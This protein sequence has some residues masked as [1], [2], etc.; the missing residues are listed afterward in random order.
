[1]FP[2]SEHRFCV[3]HLYSNFQQHFKGENLKNQLWA[4]ARS[5]TV[6]RWNE[7]MDKMKVLDQKAFEWLEKMPPNTWVRAFFSTYCKCDILLNNS[8]EVFNKY[9][10]DARE[11]PVLSMLEQIKTQLMTR[12]YKKEQEVG[13]LWEGPICPKIKRKLLKNT[14][15]ANTC[16]AQPAGMGI[17]QVKVLDRQYTVDIVNKQCDCRRWDLT[18]IPCSHAISCL[19]HERIHPE[20]VVNECYSSKRFLL[21]YGP[22]IWPTNDKSMWQRVGGPDI[23]PPVYEKKVGRPAK[24]RRKQPQEV[25]G[26]YGPKMSKHGTII[27]CS[28]CG[29]QGHNRGGCSM[30]KAGSRP[31]LVAQRNQ[32]QPPQEEYE[33]EQLTSQ[34]SMDLEEGSQPLLSQMTDTMMSQLDAEV[35]SVSNYYVSM[36]S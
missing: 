32:S 18:G 30:R 15:W 31:K 24:N 3:R 26:K 9:I 16:Y 17:F 5:T 35:T 4:C 23:L 2:E 33:D 20:E 1:M 12:Y 29:D 25:E 13:D 21:A 22:T 11:M 7:N 19:R 14:E 8:C 6:V 28:Y 27:T 10:L 34:V 36:Q